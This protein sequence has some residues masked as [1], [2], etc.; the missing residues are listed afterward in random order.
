MQRKKVRPFYLSHTGG[1]LVLTQ[2]VVKLRLTK[3]NSCSVSLTLHFST[4]MTEEKDNV[5]F[6]RY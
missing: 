3:C 5:P 4:L 2:K 6:A 1:V